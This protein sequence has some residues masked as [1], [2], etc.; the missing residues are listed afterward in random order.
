MNRTKSLSDTSMVYLS[1]GGP[2]S[3]LDHPK[4]LKVRVDNVPYSDLQDHKDSNKLSRSLSAVEFTEKIMP[5]PSLSVKNYG[6]SRR[7][8]LN[9]KMKQLQ[10]KRK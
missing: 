8:K 6:H 1:L 5:C 3:N 9:K 10:L 2:E 7:N 4:S